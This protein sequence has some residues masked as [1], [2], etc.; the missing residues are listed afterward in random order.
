MF[1]IHLALIT[2]Q[3]VRTQAQQFLI[4]L[5]SKMKQVYSIARYIIT[6]GHWDLNAQQISD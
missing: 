5:K 4:F 2:K 1:I 3:F 6:E